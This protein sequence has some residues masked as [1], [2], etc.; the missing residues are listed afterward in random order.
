MSGMLYIILGTMVLMQSNFDKD[1]GSTYNPF[2]DGMI[3]VVLL[4]NWL[5]L[6]LVYQLTIWCRVKLKIWV[7]E[8]EGKLPRTKSRKFEPS[9]PQTQPPSPE[10][11]PYVN[12]S[13][14]EKPTHFAYQ[15]SIDPEI[16]FGKKFE[17]IHVLRRNQQGTQKNLEKIQI[18]KFNDSDYKNKFMSENQKWMKDNIG[19]VLSP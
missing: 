16:T 17:M 19:S 7:V 1:P 15:Q 4:V 6:W 8:P 12:Y 2:G 10:N 3:V 11:V 13:D 5:L 9:I 18:S 14:V